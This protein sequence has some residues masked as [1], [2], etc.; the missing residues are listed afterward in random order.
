[1]KVRVV[2]QCWYE[3]KEYVQRERMVYI[4]LLD[5]LYYTIEEILNELFRLNHIKCIQITIKKIDSE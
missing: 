5:D 2:I 3:N 4:G 1:M